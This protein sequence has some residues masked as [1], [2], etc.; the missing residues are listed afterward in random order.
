MVPRQDD[1]LYIENRFDSSDRGLAVF[2]GITCYSNQD[3]KILH[4]RDPHTGEDMEFDSDVYS[5]VNA[6]DR[7]V[8]LEKIV[9][10]IHRIIHDF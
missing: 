7:I 4:C 5:W 1:I 6:M 9:D 8:S 2:S 3:K 10:S